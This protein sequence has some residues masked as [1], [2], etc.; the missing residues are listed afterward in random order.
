MQKLIK[1]TILEFSGFGG[2]NCVQ[3]GDNVPKS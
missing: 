2:D 3:R 1:H